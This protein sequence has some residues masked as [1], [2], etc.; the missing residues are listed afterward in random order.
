MRA[1]KRVQRGAERRQARGMKL[2]IAAIGA[3]L[4]A[5][6]A[7]AALAWNPGATKIT[8]REAVVKGKLSGLESAA[9][10]KA[11]LGLADQDGPPS[12]IDKTVWTMTEDGTTWVLGVGS[13]RVKNPSL[14]MSAAEARARAQLSKHLNGVKVERQRTERGTRVTR[15]A[16]GQIRGSVI[17]DWYRAEDGTTYALAAAPRPADRSP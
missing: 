14:A 9:Q 2:R 15:S 3:A 6:A 1:V 7:G 13:I 8:E 5:L 10:L 16:S 17:L 12:W 11:K 4:L